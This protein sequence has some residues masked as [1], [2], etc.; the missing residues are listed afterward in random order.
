MVRLAGATPVIVHTSVD[1]DYR[2]TSDLLAGALTERTR[3]LILCNPSNPTGAVLDKADLLA[4]ATVLANEAPQAYVLADEIYERLVYDGVEHY[5]FSA[6]TV[7]NQDGEEV[8]MWPRTLTVNGFSKAYAMTGYRLG[9]LAAP[10]ALVKACSTLQ[11]QI[12]S[13]ASSIAQQ[14]GV[15]ALKDVPEEELQELYTQMKKKR[16]LVLSHLSAI[17][18]LRCPTPTGAFYVLPDVSYYFGYTSPAGTTLTDATVLCVALLQERGVALV[19]G[20]AFGA[21]GT[22]RIS[23][24]ASV[25]ELD[26]ALERLAD[27]LAECR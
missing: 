7:E 8:S 13:C 27:W 12:S 10:R 11:S 5:A 4:L 16:D 14:A 18:G 3:M 23:Y 1:D 6:L 20:D 19:T 2:L 24:A 17:P 21:P 15:A 9:Y 22:I 26:T 25:A